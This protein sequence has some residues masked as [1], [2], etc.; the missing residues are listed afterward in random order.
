VDWFA[1]GVLCHEMA[2]GHF[3]FLHGLE[4]K[5]KLSKGVLKRVAHRDLR[6]SFALDR[7]KNNNSKFVCVPNESEWH[8]LSGLLQFDA[9]ERLGSRDTDEIY[10]H[11]WWNDSSH[12]N[13]SFSDIC[14]G[15]IDPPPFD[16][17]L[18]HGCML[19]HMEISTN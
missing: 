15:Q 13:T 9:H 11:A 2:T 10:N 17:E 18:G 1:F 5:E 12:G 7:E 3:S 19:R 4:L 6:E 14:S 16:K 8:F